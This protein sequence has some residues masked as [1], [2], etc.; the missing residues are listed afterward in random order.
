V[1]GWF[2][3]F[4]IERQVGRG[5]LGAVYRAV[6]CRSGVTAASPERQAKPRCDADGAAR[7]LDVWVVTSA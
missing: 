7:I 4:R 2:G 1:R 3:P 6:D 5:G